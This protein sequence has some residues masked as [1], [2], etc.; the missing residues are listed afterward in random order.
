MKIGAIVGR[1]QTPFLHEGHLYLINKVLKENDI[2]IIIL[3]SSKLGANILNNKNPFSFNHRVETIKYHFQKHL[4]KIIF[5]SIKDVDDDNFWNKKLDKLLEI[6]LLDF[7]YLSNLKLYGSRDSFLKTYSGAFETE[8]V[9]TKI[10][11]SATE[12]RNKYLKIIE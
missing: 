11:S 1:F 8:Y 12:I 5:L 7:G 4:N 2:C 9:E 6:Q 10:K 3:G